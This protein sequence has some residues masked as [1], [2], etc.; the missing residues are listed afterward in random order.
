MYKGSED[1]EEE[2]NFDSPEVSMA[3]KRKKKESGNF[4]S[5]F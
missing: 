1:T 5:T 3:G 4:L 2:S